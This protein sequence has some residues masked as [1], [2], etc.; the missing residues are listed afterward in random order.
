M[1]K[2]IGTKTTQEGKTM[3]VLIGGA[4]EPREPPL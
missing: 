3:M 1:T 2:R 4:M